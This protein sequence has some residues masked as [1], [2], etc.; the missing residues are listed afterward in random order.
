MAK[1]REIKKYEW[2]ENALEH[3]KRDLEGLGTTAKMIV[4]KFDEDPVNAEIFYKAA[5]EA[6]ISAG[7]IRRIEAVGRKTMDPRLLGGTV[8]RHV[9]KL[10]RLRA[11]LQKRVLDGEKFKFLTADGTILMICLRDCEKVQA[12]QM[13]ANGRIRTLP[14]Q[15]QWLEAKKSEKNIRDFKSDVPYE[16]TKKT[17]KFLQNLEMTHKQVK[18]L[19]LQ[20]P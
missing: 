17:V 1:K 15:K 3:I 9:A 4:K 13:Y 11:D 19:A 8:C 2:V 14:E 6:G 18:Q 7:F 16:I 20:L 12:E 5:A 10:R